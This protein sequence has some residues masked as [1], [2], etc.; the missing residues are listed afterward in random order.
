[1]RTIA[2]LSLAAMLVAS[3]AGS[4]GEDDTPPSPESSRGSGPNDLLLRWS[5][6]GGFTPPE[7]QLTNLPAFSLYGDGTLVRPAPQIAIYPGPA[8][9]AL[10]MTRL[11]DEAVEAVLD[12]AFDAGLGSVGDLTDMGSVGIA[13][14]PDTVFTL[15]ARGVDRVVRVYALT[16]SS[17]HPPGMPHDENRARERLLRLLEDLASLERWLPEGSVGAWAPYEPPGARAF[18]SRYRGRLDREQPPVRWPL[19]VP[20]RTGGDDLGNGFRCILVTGEDWTGGLAPVAQAANQL[21][22]WIDAGR[23]YAVT[24]R[25][26]LPDETGC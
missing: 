25:P 1:M 8:L 4:P 9:P 22:P 5:R 10:E 13:D 20:L 14:A 15:R 18:V 24:F 3:C 19:D 23:R 7:F 11:D 2:A 26:L 16:E 17:G 21:T 12:A 6:E